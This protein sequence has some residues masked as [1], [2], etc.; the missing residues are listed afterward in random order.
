MFRDLTMRRINDGIAIYKVH[1]KHKLIT[2]DNPVVYDQFIWDPSIYIRLPIDSYHI[3]SIVPFHEEI[4]FDNK[5]INRNYLDEEGSYF[6][7]TFN[8]I[9]QIE[10][11]EQFILGNRQALEE[12][13]EQSKALDPVEFERQ[14]AEYTQKIEGQLNQILE[15]NKRK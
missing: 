1:S 6:Q 10:K 13:I 9:A 2:S 5:T 11:C 3:V 14:C 4:L 12:A 8:N 7:S 15:W